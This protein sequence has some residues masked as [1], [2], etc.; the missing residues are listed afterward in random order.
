MVAHRE[1]CQE[2]SE[3]IT[4]RKAEACDAH[5][6]F[7]VSEASIAGKERWSEKL[8]SEDLND[9]GKHYF[10]AVSEADENFICGFIGA[11]HILDE[12]HIMDVAVLPAFRRMGIGGKLL[13]T[14]LA[15]AA[16]AGIRSATLEVRVS[17]ASAI[18]LYRHYGFC[19]RG[20]RKGYYPDKEDAE[21]Y[22]KEW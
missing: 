7:L 2:Y 1:K 3:K 5:A 18:A 9:T 16:E 22:W 10:A 20:I 21:I 17:N 6:I 15:N 13:K 19:S 11:A 12:A 14:C 8:F 4:I